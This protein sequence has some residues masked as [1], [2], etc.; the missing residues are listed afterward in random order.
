MKHLRFSQWALLTL[1]FAITLISIN[2]I[3]E[4]YT[5]SLY[6][7]IQ[8]YYRDETNMLHYLGW[9]VGSVLLMSIM[10]SLGVY[11][12]KLHHGSY[13]GPAYLGL[14]IGGFIA[15]SYLYDY[16]T[17]QVPFSVVLSWMVE[18]LTVCT[19]GGYLAGRIVIKK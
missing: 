11:L 16:A 6:L 8:H 2:L 5:A 3:I 7:P 15:A 19:L 17:M 13:R 1:I 10:F 4:P 9:G 18:K 14:V 12:L